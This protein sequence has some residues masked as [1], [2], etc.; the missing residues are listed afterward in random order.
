MPDIRVLLADDEVNYVRLLEPQLRSRG[1]QVSVVHDGRDALERIQEDEFD[2]AVLDLVMPELDGIALLRELREIDN[3]PEVIILT[4]SE[5]VETAVAA[6]KLGASDYVTKPCKAAELEIYIRKAHEKRQ[7]QR[8][9]LRLKTQ[10]TRQDQGAFPEIVTA[11]GMQPVLELIEK[12]APTENPVLITG[13]SGAGKELVARAIHRLSRRAE[14]PLIDINCAAI[15][16]NLLESELFGHEKGSFTGATARKLGLFELADGGT[17]FMDEIGELAPR[18]Q[19][20]LLR[21]LETGSFF[22]VGGTKQVGA[23]IRLIAAT[24]RDIARGVEDASFRQDLYYRISTLT[25]HVPP[26][27]ERPEDIPVLARHF[28]ART[29]PDA[30][31]LTGAAEEVL[32]GYS[33]PGNVRELRNVMERVAILT[34]GPE[35]SPAELPA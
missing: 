30:P 25:L 21:A 32:R 24:N 29:K 34:T 17:L 13:E 8:E 18:L 23:D 31:R 15:S 6:M 3:P 19:A 7:L 26:L 33:W 27:R 20:K 10:L 28:L 12:V 14:A 11:G 16:E 9:N 35:I 22:R 4:G 2:V 5:T 1:F